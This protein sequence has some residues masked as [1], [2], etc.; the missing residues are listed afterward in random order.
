[1]TYTP[2][3]IGSADW[4]EPVN[5]A[6]TDQD[7]RITANATNISANTAQIATNTANI[8]TN[9]A[10]IATNT[11]DISNRLVKSNNLSDLQNPA[12]ARTNLGLGNSATLN[13]GTTTGTVAAGDDSRITNAVPKGSQVV[14]V[15]DFGALGNNTGDQAAA[16]NSAIA[17]LGGNGG[18]V[19]FPPGLYRLGGSTVISL[20][21]NTALVGA[22]PEASAITIG[23]SFTGA[24]AVN[25]TGTAAQIRN[26]TIRGTAS[27][28]STNPTAFGV[29]SVNFQRFK[30]DNCHFKWINNYAAKVWGDTTNTA[31]DGT[32][33][34]G[35]TI[36]NT[37]IEACA[38]GVWVRTTNGGSISGVWPA[39]F[40][41]IGLFTRFLGLNAGTNANLDGIRIED[42]GDVLLENTF[43]W[44]N[45]GT[46]GTGA[47]LRISGNCAA[48]FI[49]NLDGLG[50]Q[51][52]I[53]NVQIESNGNGD[54]QNVQ[55]T[56]GVIQQ[57]NVGL[58]IDG[59]SN[60][61]RVRNMRILNN[62]TH[63]AVVNT[64]GSGS[65]PTTGIY[66][67]Q[68][69]FSANGAVGT[70]TNYEI[71]WTGSADGFITDCRFGSSVVTSGSGAGVQGV[72]N[73][74]TSTKVRVENFDSRGA[75]SSATN[76]FPGVNPQF[77]NYVSGSNNEYRGN[78]DMRMTGTNR[79]S[80]RSDTAGANAIA[81]NVAGAAGTDNARILGDGT[82][83]WGDGTNPRD[84]TWGRRGAGIVGTPDSHIAIGSGKGLQ[85]TAA[86]NGRMGTATL[87]SGT[88]TVANT[89]VTANTRVRTFR[90]A[91]GTVA[92]YGHLYTA[93]T[94]VGTSFQISSSSGTDNG[95]FV[96]ELFELF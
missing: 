32:T 26:L 84:T 33:L 79:L 40:Q 54:P 88:V 59:G 42:S 21:A 13:V 56:G 43:A 16:I 41:I 28:V 3:P 96:W 24:Q 67:D 29:S 6:F 11:T 72:V 60:Q 25:V 87:S 12:T 55:I 48:I 19:Y 90:I 86:A 23:S 14:N 93:A 80:M 83:N 51:T 18:Q 15:V 92:N 77:F 68:C 30:L 57:G 17:S 65:G 63:G 85:Y 73:I 46:G 76:W 70:G 53:A 91:G 4:G 22:S 78:L 38:G 94:T 89:S 74:S 34:H 45:A 20:P 5:D 61:I 50:P 82:L 7:S 62:Q 71:N 9:T 75:N 49:Q 36:V 35:G 47:A 44:M 27:T 52:G 31:T 10:N 8:A 58:N 37:T 81:F 39:N 69:T 1:V 2:I 95:S 64:V 66:I